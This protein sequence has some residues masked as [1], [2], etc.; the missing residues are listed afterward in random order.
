[1]IN[2]KSIE[3]YIIERTKALYAISY[4]CCKYN[5]LVYISTFGDVTSKNE[6]WP[7]GK[8]TTDYRRVSH[9]HFS[10]IQY[11]YNPYIEMILIKTVLA[12][13]FYLSYLYLWNENSG[14]IVR[15]YSH[16]KI[17][18]YY[19]WVLIILIK[20]VKCIFQ[21]D[22]LHFCEVFK[23]LQNSRYKR[24]MKIVQ[25]HVKISQYVLD[26][27]CTLERI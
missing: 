18:N 1:M 7:L 6:K 9:L 25:I 20:N 4:R 2:N 16:E 13:E 15:V 5:I 3:V 11:L 12:S 22:G 23:L 21:R 17:W 8:K 26:N 24:V 14:L 19:S 10:N 27:K